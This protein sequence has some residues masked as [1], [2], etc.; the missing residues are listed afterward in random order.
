MY[1]NYFF[2]LYTQYCIIPDRFY[3]SPSFFYI[4]MQPLGD[5]IQKVLYNSLTAKALKLER[6]D[7]LDIAFGTSGYKLQLAAKSDRVG[8]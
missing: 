4:S 2:S 8:R 7:I 6:L 1:T 5:T 3:A